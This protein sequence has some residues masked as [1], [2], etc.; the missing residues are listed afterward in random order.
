VL[1]ATTMDRRWP[2]VLDGL[3][4]DTPP[5]SKGTLVACRQRLIARELR[6]DRAY[7]A[8]MLVQQRPA[9]LAIFCQAWPASAAEG[10]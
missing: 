7:V 3:D 6:L 1:E 5:F 9:D 4:C 10:V 8:T 2:L